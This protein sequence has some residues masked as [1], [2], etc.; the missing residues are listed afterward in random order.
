MQMSDDKCIVLLK[1]HNA[2]FC[3]NAYVFVI[4]YALCLRDLLVC[5]S[6]IA[7]NRESMIMIHLFQ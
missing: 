3:F 1:G 4:D 7:S 5:L 6:I 2:A